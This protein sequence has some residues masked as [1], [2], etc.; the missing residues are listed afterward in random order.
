MPRHKTNECLLLRLPLELRL[1]IYETCSAFTLLHL[2]LTCAQ[3]RAEVAARPEIYTNTY[4]YDTNTAGP[5]SMYNIRLVKDWTE[6]RVLL[7][8]YQV[9]RQRGSIWGASPLLHLPL[10]LRLEIYSHCSTFALLLLSSTCHQA[11]AEITSRPALY[12]QTMGYVR[13]RPGARDCLSVC[14]VRFVT[15]EEE[16]ALMK[17]LYGVPTRLDTLP[18]DLWKYWFCC[19][20]CFE[21]RCDVRREGEVRVAAEEKK[22]CNFCAMRVMYGDCKCLECQLRPINREDIKGA[23]LFKS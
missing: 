17:R 15:C 6:R 2:S 19:G 13:E 9:S 3:L 18:G 16:K 20:N 14:Y 12:T 21:V 8:R 10:E 1:I 4:G 23:R 7:E 11:R 22:L 5:L